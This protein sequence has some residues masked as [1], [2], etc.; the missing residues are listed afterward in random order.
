MADDDDMVSTR[1]SRRRE[2]EDER[3]RLR[4]ELRALSAATPDGEPG[5]NVETRLSVLEQHIEAIDDALERIALAEEMERQ[6]DA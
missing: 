3:A 2:L 4:A 5:A 6:Q 1:T